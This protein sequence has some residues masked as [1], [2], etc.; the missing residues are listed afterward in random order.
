LRN[1]PNLLSSSDRFHPRA[2][3]KREEAAAGVGAP[4]YQQSS[5]LAQAVTLSAKVKFEPAVAGAPNIYVDGGHVGRSTRH[6]ATG[7]CGETRE[8]E[9]QVRL[10][11]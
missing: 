2:T 7:W 6:S 11:K 5:L 1:E 10:S 4:L 8:I 9:L 3:Q